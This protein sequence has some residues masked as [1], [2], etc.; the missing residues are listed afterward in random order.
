[1]KLLSDPPWYDEIIG[2]GEPPSLGVVIWI[3]SPSLWNRDGLCFRP[4][5]D[6]EMENGS[7]I[8]YRSAS[9]SGAC[10]LREWHSTPLV[11][12]RKVEQ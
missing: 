8:A 4:K 11:P 3:P 12:V 7:M 10:A 9:E 6:A 5:G 1:M 2:E